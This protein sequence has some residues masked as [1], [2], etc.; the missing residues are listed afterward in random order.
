LVTFPA[1]K[2]PERGGVVMSGQLP[3]A[4]VPS[5]VSLVSTN[6]QAA[7]GLT[8][9][10]P[11]ASNPG[12]TRSSTPGSTVGVTVGVEVGGAGVNVEVG[13]AGVGVSALTSTSEMS[14]RCMVAIYVAKVCANRMTRVAVLPVGT[15]CA[16]E[17]CCQLLITVLPGMEYRLFSVP[18]NGPSTQLIPNVSS[19]PSCLTSQKPAS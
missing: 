18:P 16:P 1:Q 7:G 6:P 19:V 10:V 9:S 13:G 3:A 12:L 11:S 5:Q 14:S 2:V 17:Y 15:N 8:K 4:R